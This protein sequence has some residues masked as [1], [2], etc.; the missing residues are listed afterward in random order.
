MNTDIIIVG[1]ILIFVSAI[2]VAEFLRAFYHKKF[3]KAL[4]MKGLASACFVAFGAYNFFSREFSWPTLAIFVGLCWGIIGDEIIALC[5]IYPNSD[6]QHFIGGGVFFV[7]GHVF[8]VLALL[9]LTGFNPIYV[10]LVL[11]VAVVLSTIYGRK[12]DYL[13][14]NIKNSLRLYLGIVAVFTAISVS[15]FLSKSSYGTALFAL[16]GILFTISDNILFAFKYGNR[17]R[18]RQNVTLHI[19]YYIAQFAIALSIALL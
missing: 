2:F 8:Y 4:L 7:V 13:P 10:A 18:Y 9:I 6:T 15:G 14:E 1:L 11:A 12:R 16:G 17:P 3:K 5:Q 19:A